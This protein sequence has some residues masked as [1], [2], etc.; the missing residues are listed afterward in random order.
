MTMTQRPQAARS[1]PALSPFAADVLDG[2]S[3]P[4]KALPSRWLYDAEGSSLF[5]EITELAEYYPTRTELAIL[6]EQASELVAGVP[7]GAVLVEF[8][9]G[10]SIKTELVL[11]AL[12]R[13]GTYVPIDISPSALDGAKARLAQ[14]F[15]GLDVSPVVGDFTSIERLPA[16]ARRPAPFRLGFFPGSTIGNFEPEDAASLL[17]RFR[18][19]LGAPAELIVGVDLHKDVGTLE[20]AYDD[21][22]GVTARFNLNLLTR[23]NRE[24]GG[25]FDLSR[26]RHRAIYNAAVGRIEMHLEALAG[27]EVEV[28]GRTFAFAQGESIHTENCYKYSIE[29]FRDL[30][31]RAGWTPRGVCTDADRRFSVHRLA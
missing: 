10:S 17:S 15:P 18:R 20:R 29:G 28:L 5:E 24:L 8:G 14:R 16:A 9:S 6:R 12:D 19:L 25:D 26:F 3:R 13:V 7:P 11:A 23:I 2:L 21:A 31:R 30:A 22:K 27:H 1:K 4:Q